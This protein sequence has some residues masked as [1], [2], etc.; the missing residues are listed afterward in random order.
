MVILWY[1]CLQGIINQS[2]RMKSPQYALVTTGT[3]TYR[4]PQAK[5]CCTAGRRA[6]R[7]FLIRGRMSEHKIASEDL[8]LHRT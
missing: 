5:N 1:A 7:K 3:P 8:T 2:K 6:E 4:E